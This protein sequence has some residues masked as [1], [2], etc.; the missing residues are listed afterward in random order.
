MI[1][2]KIKMENN[3]VHIKQ[4]VV[5]NLEENYIYNEECSYC[6]DDPVKIHF[7]IF[8]IRKMKVELIFV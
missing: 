8:L 3:C 6:L 4:D 2:L 7:L 5:Y 1:I